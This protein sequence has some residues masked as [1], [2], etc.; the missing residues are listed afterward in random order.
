MGRGSTTQ[1]GL[2]GSIERVSQ[3]AKPSRIQSEVRTETRSACRT[4]AD[5]VQSHQHVL[6]AGNTR[7]WGPQG[8]LLFSGASMPRQAIPPGIGFATLPAFAT[9]ACADPGSPPRWAA[10]HRRSNLRYAPPSAI[11]IPA[12]PHHHRCHRSLLGPP[13]CGGAAIRH[14][15]RGAGWRA[16][17][18]LRT[19]RCR[20]RARH[21]RPARKGG[22]CVAGSGSAGHGGPS[23]QV[24]QGA[25]SGNPEIRRP[26]RTGGGV[27]RDPATRAREARRP[28]TMRGTARESSRSDPLAKIILLLG[29]LSPW[30]RR[31]L[32]TWWRSGSRR[33]KP[34]DA[35][36]EDRRRLAGSAGS[37]NRALQ[38]FAP[39]LGACLEVHF[40]DLFQRL[41]HTSQ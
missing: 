37:V 10:G 4:T 19:A 29:R 41:Q 2:Y 13:S 27:H 24:R 15:R 17:W 18:D 31:R 9:T 12:A 11:R 39:Q 21:R 7:G 5:G 22:G 36:L 1:G 33:S 25:I 34:C 6:T 38:S 16:A 20:R 28:P 14:G 8:P 3:L 26:R 23:P 32:A 30:A 40:A 35:G